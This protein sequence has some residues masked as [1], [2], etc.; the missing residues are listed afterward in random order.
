MTPKMGV[1]TLISQENE[2]DNEGDDDKAS[3]K[4]YIF[5]EGSCFCK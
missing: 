2:G 1:Y 5:G 4:K 3:R